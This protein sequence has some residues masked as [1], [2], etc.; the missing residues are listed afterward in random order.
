[1]TPSQVERRQ[2]HP[3]VMFVVNNYPPRVGGVEMHVGHLAA[4]LVRLGA[5]VTVFT[6]DNQNRS[7]QESGVDVHR[8]RGT[9]ALADVLALPWPGTRKAL[10]SFAA[11]NGVD[12]IS[13]HT[14]FFP[15]SYLGVRAAGRLGLPVVHTEHGSGHVR[16][17]ASVVAL[18]SR[19]VDLTLGRYVLRHATVVLGVSTA[20]ADFVRRLA[21]VPCRTFVN[22]IPVADFR[23][24]HPIE[25]AGVA[26]R[27]VYVGRIVPGKGWDRI[28]RVAERL[29]PEIHDLSVHIVGNGPLQ[30]ALN[31]QVAASTIRDHI[32]LHGRL[33]PADVAPILR[34][35]VL[36]NPTNLAEGFQTTLLESIAAGGLVVSSPVAAA[37]TLREMGAAVRIVHSDDDDAWLGE[38]RDAL[39]DGW[40]P[41]ASSLVDAFDWASRAG[42]YLEIVASV[43]GSARSS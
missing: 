12:V 24:A 5:Q 3:H 1:M 29:V 43:T 16:G 34:G 27:L 40:S 7:G 18:A 30:E 28:L 20:V 38:I 17:V 14:R 2:P 21:G 32:I 42:E 11:N 23:P 31:A 39:R 37:R 22:G 33:T 19:I 13:T 4:H 6:L 15:M 8:L 35:A 10:T 41:T 9:R 25:P 26:Q 36:V